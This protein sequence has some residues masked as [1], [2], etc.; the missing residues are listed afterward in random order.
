MPRPHVHVTGNVLLL[1]PLLLPLLLLLL[2]LLLLVPLQV[3]AIHH[4]HVACFPECSFEI[5][6]FDCA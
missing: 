1:L 5:T 4:C 3:S 6:V 2:L